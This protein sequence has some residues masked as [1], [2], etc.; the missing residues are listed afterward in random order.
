MRPIPKKLLIHT[1][2][3][4]RAESKDRWGKVT[5][6]AEAEL[7][8]VRMEPSSKIVRDKSNAEVQLAAVLIYDCRNSRPRGTTFMEDDVIVFNGQRHKV[9]TVEALYD[10]KR[11]HHYEMGLIASA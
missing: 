11:L 7:T 3:M 4:S 9:Q 8:Y 1:V 5:P 2:T 10:E 6:G